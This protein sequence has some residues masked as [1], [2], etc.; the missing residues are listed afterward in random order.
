MKN[1]FVIEQA[2][3]SGCAAA[4]SLLLA[5]GG[6]RAGSGWMVFAAGALAVGWMAGRRF[7]WFSWNWLPGVLLGI[8][9]AAAAAG[10]IEGA[11][12]HLMAGGAAAALAAF[13]LSEYGGGIDVNAELREMF[14][15]RRLTLLGIVMA[16]G[17]LAAAAG[18]LLNASVPFCGLGLAALAMVYGLLK[19]YETMKA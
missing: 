10:V 2:I 8:S 13:E 18:R 16:G 6:W 11:S 1:I 4:A 9:C 7:D 19:L 17:L 3:F 14:V 15:R 12:F 5:V